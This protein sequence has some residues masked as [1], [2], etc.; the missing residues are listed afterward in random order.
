MVVVVVVVVVVGLLSSLTLRSSPSPPP[1]P[2]LAPSYLPREQCG[3][4]CVTMLM[5]GLRAL[6]GPHAAD[7]ADPEAAWIPP[8]LGQCPRGPPG[9]AT[10]LSLPTCLI[11]Y[12]NVRCEHAAVAPRLQNGGRI[13]HKICSA[14]RLRG[15][16]SRAGAKLRGRASP[17]S[18]KAW[19]PGTSRRVSEVSERR[20]SPPGAPGLLSR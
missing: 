8:G 13:C 19:K 7:F 10:P 15:G 16:R 14:Y 12:S 18:Q 20:H 4:S 9:P 1:P 17:E 6:M 11:W 5:L 3:P 2:L